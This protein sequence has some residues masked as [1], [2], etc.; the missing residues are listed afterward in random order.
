[1]SGLHAL[2]RKLLRDFRRLWA[3]V[4]AIAL[5]LAC[6]VAILLTSFGMYRALDETRAAYYQRNRFADV[7]VEARRAP[8]ALL[9]EIA[10]IPGV[11]A[12]EGRVTG[13]VVLD[14]PGR[15]EAAVGR[16]LSLPDH[17]EPRL[18][19]PL[20]RS[21]RLPDTPSEIAVN[22]PFADANGY[23]PGDTILANLNGRKRTLTITGTLLSPEFIYTLGPGALMPDN[24]GFGILWMR[25]AGAEAAFDM[26]GAFNDLALKIDA[27]TKAEP[28]ID[29]LDDLLDPYGGFGAYGRDKQLSNA[30]IDAEIRQL[31]SMAMILPPVFFGISAFLVAMVM[32]RIVTLE[33]AQIGLLKALGYGNGAVCLHYLLLAGLIALV[34]IAT[35]WVAGTWLARGL[36]HLYAN[37]FDFPFV[38]FR[39]AP[40]VYGLSAVLALA[41][42]TLG[43]TQSALRAAR[44]APAI[45]MQPPA[46]PKFTQSA[47]DRAMDRANLT[48]PT[49]MIL[50]SLVRW[51]VR[52]ALTA[53]GLALAVASVMTA[54]FMTDALDFVVDSAF[55]QSNRQHAML[56]FQSDAPLSALQD[57]A[58][59]PGVRQVEGQ[60]IAAAVL[61]R[62]HHEKQVAI[63]ARLPGADLSRIV[64]ADGGARD[65]PP[66][67]IL[68]SERVAGQL[69]VRP[70]QTITAELLGGNQGTYTFEVAGIVPQYFGLGAYV[71][72]EGFNRL[73]RQAP[74]VSV[75]NITLDGARHD[76]LHAAIKD[77]PGI[78]GTVMMTHTRR[79]FQ[80]TIRQNVTIM[81]TVYITIAVL[82]SVGVGYNSARIQLSERARELASLR[83]LGFSRWQVSYILVGEL[84]LLAVLAQPLGWLLGRVF[85]GLMVRAFSS[86]LYN[87]PLVLKPATFSFASLIVLGATLAAVLVVRRRLDR[88]DLV[89][90]MKTRE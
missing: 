76:A 26:G 82:I 47:F 17:A 5:V 10:A 1:M 23:R 9:A 39:I 87:L 24:E 80:E 38:I 20:L 88:L 40:W 15:V 61:R 74:R 68:L 63:E 60:Q 53:L 58:H 72:L 34:G 70:G 12:V 79:S 51:P 4:L 69:D 66:G 27:S 89:A 81:L 49:V 18:N 42:T 54:S 31:R 64:A 46:P 21:G 83:I 8:L 55:Y 35:G 71:D 86:D 30:F 36:A 67:G 59:L 62:G 28:V 85:T 32:G 77:T 50:R 56:I 48:Q 84:M 44:L 65:A 13:D 14:L 22:E 6:G 75:A 52:S 16:V 25:R 78:A 29:A 33:R 7:F 57:V 19:L 90:V 11:Q 2:D 37:F 45:A 73:L 41:A 43:A 3:Q